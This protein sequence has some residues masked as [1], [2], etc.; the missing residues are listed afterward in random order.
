[1]Y[2]AKAT[3]SEEEP[4]PINTKVAM[5]NVLDSSLFCTVRLVGLYKVIY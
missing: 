2:S 3:S 5:S 4:V 1:M